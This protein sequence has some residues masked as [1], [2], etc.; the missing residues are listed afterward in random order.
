[1]LSL[2]PS[3]TLQHALS[4]KQLRDHEVADILVCPVGEMTGYTGDE[5]DVED[6]PVSI[7]ENLARERER[8]VIELVSM[9]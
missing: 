9:G 5:R 4:S 2:P 7:S 1:M 8:G 3:L 6:A